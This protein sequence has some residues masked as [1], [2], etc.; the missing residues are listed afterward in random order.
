MNVPDQLF[1]TKD[2]EWV[3]FDQ[4]KITIGITDY[5]QSQLGDIIFV[6]MPLAGDT[7]AV[8]NTFGEIEAVKTVSELY[9]PLSGTVIAVND[10]IEKEPESVNT[11]PYGKGWLIKLKCSNELE[12]SSLLSSSEYEKLI[13]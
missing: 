9:A 2:H 8:G 13:S 10:C 1:Y 7:F 11:D 6:E 5:A 4:D 12:K 3:E